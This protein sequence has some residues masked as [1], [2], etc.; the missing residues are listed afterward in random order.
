MGKRAVKQIFSN[1]LLSVELVLATIANI[2]YRGTMELPELSRDQK[3]MFKT[4]Q[5]RLV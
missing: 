4:V 5:K 3:E 1:K 2:T